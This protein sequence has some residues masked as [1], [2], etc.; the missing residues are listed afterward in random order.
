MFVDWEKGSDKKSGKTPK[1]AVKTIARALGEPKVSLIIV[2]GEK[3][4]KFMKRRDK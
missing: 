1:E 3:V 2:L 4:K